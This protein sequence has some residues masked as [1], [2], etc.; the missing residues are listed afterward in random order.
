MNKYRIKVKGTLYAFSDKETVTRIEDMLAEEFPGS[1]V[2]VHVTP[3][4][5]AMTAIDVGVLYEDGHWE[6]ARV[7][8]PLFVVRRCNPDDF[9]EWVRF[10]KAGQIWFNSLNDVAGYAVLWWGD[11]A[12]AT[13]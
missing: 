1:K 10:E 7:R 11:H 6:R 8:V 5:T 12:D 9:E 13:W 2:E 3:T 4:K